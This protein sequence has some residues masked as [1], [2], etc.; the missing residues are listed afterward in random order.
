MARYRYVGDDPRTFPTLGLEVTPGGV[1]DI[2]PALL[3]TTSLP[4]LL[5]PI[6]EAKKPQE[7]TPKAPT[8][9]VASVP[10]P[11]PDASADATDPQE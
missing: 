7:K 8:P 9:A 4:A 10:K 1:Y 3:S 5:E 6:A 2:D 11:T